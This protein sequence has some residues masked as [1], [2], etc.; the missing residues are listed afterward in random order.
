[1]LPNR[2]ASALSGTWSAN[3]VV[4]EDPWMPT[5]DP[6]AHVISD[7]NPMTPETDS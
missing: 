6:P 7:T 3:P 5:L 1:M 4:E 2:G